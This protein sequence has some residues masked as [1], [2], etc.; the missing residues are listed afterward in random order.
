MGSGADGHSYT[1]SSVMTY[2]NSGQGQPKVFQASTST[3]KAPGGVSR[4]CFAQNIFQLANFCLAFQIKETRKMLRDSDRGVEKMAVGRHIRDRAYIQTKE[5]DRSGQM[6]ED[7]Q[8]LNIDD[9]SHFE[10]EW[11][12]HARTFADRTRQLDGGAGRRPSNHASIGRHQ[13]RQQAAPHQSRPA[14]EY[15]RH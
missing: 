15:R 5:R 14:I 10:D 1:H 7:E 12:S 2:S 3:A 13:R 6:N 8:L 9:R 11:R 4:S